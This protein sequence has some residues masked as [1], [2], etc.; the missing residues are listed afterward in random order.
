MKRDSK[1]RPDLVTVLMVLIA[2]A[3]LSILTME[4]WMPHGLR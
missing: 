1:F 3:V 4:F 2:L